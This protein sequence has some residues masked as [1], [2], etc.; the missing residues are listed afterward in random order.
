MAG[1]TGI[2]KVWQQSPRGTTGGCVLFVG[3]KVVEFQ[4]EGTGLILEKEVLAGLS[5]NPSLLKLS[6]GASGLAGGWNNMRT[7][8]CQ[9]Y[10]IGPAPTTL[11]ASSHSKLER[12]TPNS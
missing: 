12:A 2:R 3:G 1:D 5:P 11:R 8:C 7:E 10:C 4:D 9:V 6:L